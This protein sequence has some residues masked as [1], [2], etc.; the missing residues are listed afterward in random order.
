MLDQ[1]VPPQVECLL[2]TWVSR[3][4]ATQ[5]K[6]RAGRT[7]AGVCYHLFTR[8]K[9]ATL[10]EYQE[11]EILRV[12]L[13]QLCLQIKVLGLANTGSV[14][15][16]LGKVRHG[17]SGTVALRV[18]LTVGRGCCRLSTPRRVPPLTTRSWC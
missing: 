14:R 18:A 8:A 12:P 16:F 9:M 5:R 4:S 13:Q 7:R 2:P 6:G 17:A 1:Y 11:P 10:P 15:D 3:A